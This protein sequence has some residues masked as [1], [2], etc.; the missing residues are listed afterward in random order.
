VVS[1]EAPL[2]NRARLQFVESLRGLAACQVVLLH[3]CA[4]FLPVLARVPGEA[5]FP[6]EKWLSHSPLFLL[7][8]GYSSVYLFFVMSGFV[9]AP[10]FLHTRQAVG[11]IVLKRFVRLYL[12]VLAA[13]VLALLLLAALPYAKTAALTHARS[14]WLDFMNHNP[15]QLQTLLQDGLWN[16][17]LA[18][19]QNLSVFSPW[20]EVAAL[21]RV[22][23]LETAMNSP[24]WTLHVEFWGS[25]LLIVL[26]LAQRCL[27]GW[28][29]WPLALLL[30]WCAGTSQFLLFLAGYGLYQLHAAWQAASSR[31]ATPAGAVCVLLGLYICASKQVPVLSAGWAQLGQLGVY[32]ADSDFHWQSQLG[33][34]L[35]FTG[36]L[37]CVPLQ[38]VLSHPRLVALGRLSFSVYLLHFPVLISLGCLLFALCAPYSYGL[39]FAT[40]LLLGGAFTFVLAYW[41]ERWIDRQAVTLGRR[42]GS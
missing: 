32:H 5:H 34:L 33:A 39:A 42:L 22:A 8:D 36:A 18:G 21:M 7:L 15:M 11:R 24:M 38:R 20:P 30:C 16:A 35:V 29:S 28:L 27:P 14:P 40:S 3:Y 19:Y 26:A 23:P 6:G 4:A 1:Q 9:L 25:M 31:M 10:S 2:A 37:L 17:M 12:P 41:F 13:F